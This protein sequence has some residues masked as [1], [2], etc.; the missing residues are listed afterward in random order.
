M[1]KENEKGETRNKPTEHTKMS[2]KRKER[3]IIFSMKT[4][5]T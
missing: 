1:R 2:F 5:K 4:G 3:R